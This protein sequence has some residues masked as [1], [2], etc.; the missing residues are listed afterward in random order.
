[1]YRGKKVSFYF[2]CR[3]E[4][5]HLAREVARLPSF[6]DE[7]IVVDNRSTDG[8]FEVAES[9]GVRA[10]QDNRAKGGIGYGFAHMTGLAHATGDVI[11]TADA[12]GTYPIDR[13]APMIDRMLDEDIDFLSCNRYPLKDPA[14]VPLVLRLGVWA[15]TTEASMLYATRIRD[16]LSGMWLVRREAVPKLGLTEGDWNLSPQ[17]KLNAAT[18]PE[19]RF[20]EEHITLSAREGTTKQQY[21]KTGLSHLWWIAKNRFARQRTGT[22]S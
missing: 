13:L 9:L 22:T 19:L 20:S 14:G 1:M 21:L 6:V 3:N 18:H 2:P 5:A 7:V 16:I 15:L 8:T 17:I 12:D 10:V 11:A 4:A